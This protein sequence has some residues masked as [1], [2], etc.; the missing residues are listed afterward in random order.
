M[1]AINLTITGVVQGVGFRFS[2]LQLARKF[3]VT[4]FVANRLDGSVY[5][6]AQGNSEDI[7]KFSAAIK[8]NPSPFAK[9]KRVVIK[10]QLTQDF[11]S[12][13]IK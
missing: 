13:T 9:I 11:S 6:E 12:F 1:K 8:Q 7:E 3:N 10:N 5:I 4:G 2:T